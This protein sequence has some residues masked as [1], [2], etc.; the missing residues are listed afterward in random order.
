MNADVSAG[1]EP[2]LLERLMALH[3]ARHGY[4]A[5]LESATAVA[6]PSLRDFLAD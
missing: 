3:V 6:V 4:E 1:D 5:T 2:E